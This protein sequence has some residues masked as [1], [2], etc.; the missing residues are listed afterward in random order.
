MDFYHNV[1]GT[2]IVPVPK[3]GK[4]ASCSQNNRPITLA[5]TLSKVLEHLILLQHQSIFQSSHLQFGFKANSSTTLCTALMKMV[6]SWYRNS[7]SCVLDAS[8]AF[9]RVDHGLLF[10]KLGLPPAI[11]NFLLSWYH[12]Q[13]MKVQW[14]PKSTQIVLQ[15]PMVSA[16]VVYC[17]LSYLLFRGGSRIDGRGVLRRGIFVPRPLMTSFSHNVIFAHMPR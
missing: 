4:D 9:D 6:I 2:V 7:G 8:K 17:L 12:T 10:Q 13:Q 14:D 1:F 15:S 5:S 11:L 16:K 3:P